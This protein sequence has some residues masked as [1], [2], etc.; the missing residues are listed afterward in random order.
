MA[1]DSNSPES[2]LTTLTETPGKIRAL[3]DGVEPEVLHA[4]PADGEWSVNEV[5]AHLRAAADVWEDGISRMLTEDHPTIRAG[6]P[7]A[8]MER[9][10]YAELPFSESFE[11]F[12]E[13]RSRL[14]DILG[15]LP[16]DG[17]ARSADI[18]GAGG[19]RVQTVQAY[20]R[21]IASH[22]PLHIEQIE[23]AIRALQ[24]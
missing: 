2:I 18:V 21:R 20:A 15:S 14:L 6:N 5:V 8:Q 19:T 24:G 11:A 9:S 23:A 13:Q 12:S 7:G 16:E 22:E 3:T 17:W 4:A 10:N 1:H